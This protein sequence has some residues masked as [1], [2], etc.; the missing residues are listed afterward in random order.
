MKLSTL[1]AVPPGVVTDNWPVVA[2]SGTLALTEVLLTTVKLLAAVPLKLTPV[3]PVKAV[4]VMVTE[5]PTFPLVG[6]KAVSVGV[7]LKFPALVA[8][9][10]GVVT[11]IFPD[12]TPTGTTVVSD[13]S[14]TTLKLLAVDPLNLIAVAPV[15]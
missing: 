9:P 14:L 7:T 4:P 8:V 12:V 5:S 2:P 11:V 10:F 1:V 3:A 6:A 15:K 13:V